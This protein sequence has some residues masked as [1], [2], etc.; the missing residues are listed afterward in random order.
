[1]QIPAPT[2]QP[3]P[4]VTIPIAQAQLLKQCILV[5][6]RC[7]HSMTIVPINAF[8]RWGEYRRDTQIAIN[9]LLSR[10]QSLGVTIPT[11][12]SR[13]HPNWT[14]QLSSTSP[15]PGWIWLSGTETINEYLRHMPDVT[16]TPPAN[17]TRLPIP[18]Q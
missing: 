1:M 12:I 4:G 15:K 13:H 14:K 18:L 7:G 8:P 16:T 11:P 2:Q 3:A 5:R 9:R 6:T 10:H 17:Q